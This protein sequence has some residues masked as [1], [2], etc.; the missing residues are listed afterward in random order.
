[1]TEEQGGYTDGTEGYISAP[2]S[3][4]A[5]PQPEHEELILIRRQEI[6]RLVRR[7]KRF[8]QPARSARDWALAWLGIAAGLAASLI[9]VT[10]STEDVA[11]WV[12]PALI[13]G[14][15]AAGFLFGFCLWFARD[16]Q[17]QRRVDMGDIAEELEEIENRSPAPDDSAR[18]TA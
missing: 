12:V 3:R 11:A 5:L 14:T 4:I 9:P 15:V 1:M 17:K 6:R 10:Q 16:Q 13:I 2:A 8:G 7:C 18:S